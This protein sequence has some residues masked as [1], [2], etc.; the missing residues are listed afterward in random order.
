MSNPTK[1]PTE[2]A[3]AVYSNFD[4]ELDAEVVKDLMSSPD[5][6]YAQHAA[7]N[8]CGY[9]WFDGKTWHEDVWVHGNLVQTLSNTDLPALIASVN[10]EYGDK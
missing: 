7:W 4:H 3:H 2:I 8:F 1:P 10:N 5:E 6:C 9:V